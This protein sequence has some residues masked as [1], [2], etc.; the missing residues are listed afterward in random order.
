MTAIGFIGLGAMG[1]R[2]ALR[3][4]DA[5]HDL[6]VWN[7][8]TTRADDLVAAGASFAS[9]PRR[10]ADNA[11]VVVTM[12]A[13][14]L[15]LRQVSAGPDGA[16]AGLHPGAL[17]IE[18]ST[19]GTTAIDEL[20]SVLGHG[21]RLVD[22]PVLGTLPEAEAGT[23]QIFAG[24]DD[25]DVATAARVLDSLG[26]VRH[27]GPLGSGAAAKLVV[28]AALY[29]MVTLFGETVALGDSLG[30]DRASLFSAL[31]TSPIGAQAERRRPAFD[32]DTYPTR[33]RLA[34][35]VKDLELIDAAGGTTELPLI[36]SALEWF[37]RALPR[38]PEE[39]YTSVLRT[40]VS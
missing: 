17:W 9:S 32:A 10:A 40:I 22:A 6:T 2:M 20:D 23:L 1:S 27:V 28:N 39:D 8:T 11:D 19:V 35:A 33:F 24:G 5:G 7:R 4:L 37:R 34:L 25:G 3:L 12:L 26:T 14:P 15:A 29:G 31:A 36:R 16:A 21:A 38:S 13:D 30:L 18:M